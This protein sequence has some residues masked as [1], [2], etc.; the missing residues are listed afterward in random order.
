MVPSLNPQ[1]HTAAAISSW[2]CCAGVW[3]NAP[4]ITKCLCARATAGVGVRVRRRAT[5]LVSRLCEGGECE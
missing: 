3:L 1:M 2:Q 5:L 4:A